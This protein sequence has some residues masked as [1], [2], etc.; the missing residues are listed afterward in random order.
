MER[1]SGS[2]A[3]RRDQRDHE[4]DADRERDSEAEKGFEHDGLSDAGYELRIE[5]EEAEG[6]CA[7]GEEDDVGHEYTSV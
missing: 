2:E 6:A 4:I 7:E 3:L 1:T 5:R